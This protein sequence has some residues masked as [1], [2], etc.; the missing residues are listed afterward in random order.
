MRWRSL[1]QWRNS[2]YSLAV[3]LSTTPTTTCTFSPSTHLPTSLASQSSLRS[4]LVC[5][6]TAA[7]ATLTTVSLVDLP[8]TRIFAPTVKAS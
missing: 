2:S 1:G 8:V 7:G 4:L 6:L 3:E 5:S